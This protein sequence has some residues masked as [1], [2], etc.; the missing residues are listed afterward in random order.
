MLWKL[1]AL[2]RIKMLLWR[3]GS[4]SLPTKENLMSR[5]GFNDSICVLCGHAVVSRIHLFLK[6]PAAR[7]IRCASIWG[8]RFDSSQDGCG[9]SQPCIPLESKCLCL[10]YIT[11]EQFR[12]YFFPKKWRR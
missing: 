6:C 11:Y 3:I 1:K 10:V 4:N 8:I 7:A 2:K 5:L 9:F 12:L